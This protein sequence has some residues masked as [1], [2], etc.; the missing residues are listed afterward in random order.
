MSGVST[1]TQGRTHP[2][3]QQLAYFCTVQKIKV[4]PLLLKEMTKSFV[5][6]KQFYNGIAA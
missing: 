3:R 4:L 6:S 2:Q 1:Y 5:M